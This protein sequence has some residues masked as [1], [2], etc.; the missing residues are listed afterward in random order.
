M[1]R[2]RLSTFMIDCLEESF[3]DS[4]AFWSEALG[5]PPARK[6]SANQ[7]YLT[8]GTIAGPIHVRMQKVNSDP[9][10]HLDIETDDVSGEVQR[11]E[12]HGGTRKYR[13]KRWW[14][15][16][17]PTGNAFCVVRPE[18]EKFPSGAKRWSDRT[19]SQRIRKA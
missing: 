6:P 12:N 4:V 5:L 10:Y 8:L 13:I 7:R 18:S 16:E 9:G 19:P 2:S 1:H 14:V 3:D 11:L 17:D 15:M